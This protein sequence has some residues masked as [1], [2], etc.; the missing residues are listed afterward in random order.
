MHL[1]Y[2]SNRYAILYNFYIDSIMDGLLVIDCL[3]SFFSV[4]IK[5]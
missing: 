3:V 5:L 1:I 2:Y 4:V